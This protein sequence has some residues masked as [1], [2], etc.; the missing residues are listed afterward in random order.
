LEDIEE[1]RDVRNLIFNRLQMDNNTPDYDLQR[2]VMELFGERYGDMTPKDWAHI[3]HN[4]TS[5]VREANKAREIPLYYPK[6]AEE[7]SRI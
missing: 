3:I 5:M 4:Y 6:A 7:D 2:E 1:D